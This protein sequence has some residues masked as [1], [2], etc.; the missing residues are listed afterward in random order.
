[1][2][3]ELILTFKIL[4]PLF[5]GGAHQN[6]ELRPPSFKGLLRFWYRAIDPAFARYDEGVNRP[7]REE[8][9]FG[10]T[11]LNA[12]QS[13]FLLHLNPKELAKVDWSTLNPRRFDKGSGRQTRNGLVYLGFPFGMRD[14]GREA[15]TPGQDFELHC[16]IT[17]ENDNPTFRRALL[18]AWWL[19]GHLGA[20]GSRSRRGFGSLALT[21]WQLWPENIVWPEK[22]QLP[23]LWREADPNAWKSGF[24]RGMTTLREWFGTHEKRFR[25]PHLGPAFT[26]SLANEGL[27]AQQWQQALDTLGRRLQDFRQRRQPDYDTVKNHLLAAARQGGQPL[28]S[29]P[30]RASFGL[31]LT[32]RYSSARGTVTF[33]PYDDDLKTTRERQGSLLFLRLAALGDRV[34]PLYLRLDGDVPGVDSKVAIR[35]QGRELASTTANALDEFMA[36]LKRES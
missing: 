35:G 21:Q 2:A 36:S 9:F 22:D 3:T 29:S 16:V 28:R 32:F 6:P 4:T 27:P 10:G 31:P 14:G 7:C 23:L 1:M 8:R 20:A 26:W 24:Q 30:T 13:P 34:H 18:A 33:A 17:R 19:L 15:I 25:H 11:L 5:L 12:G